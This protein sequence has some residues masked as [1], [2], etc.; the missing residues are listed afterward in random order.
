[1]SSKLELGS[2]Y[3]RAAAATG[4]TQ[5][6]PKMLA[7]VE[8]EGKEVLSLSHFLLSSVLPVPFAGGIQQGL[9]E[10][11]AQSGSARLAEEGAAWI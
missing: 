11:R 2:T 3:L 10:P 9:Q 7:K 8:G 5:L 4:N 6:L 1:M